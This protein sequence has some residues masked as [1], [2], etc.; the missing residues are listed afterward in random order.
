[1]FAWRCYL[2]LL[3]MILYLFTDVN[4]TFIANENYCQSHM[5]NTKLYS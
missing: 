3:Q 2:Q 5:K 1:M 4:L